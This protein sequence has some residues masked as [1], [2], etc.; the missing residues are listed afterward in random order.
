[1]HHPIIPDI[2]ANSKRVDQRSIGCLLL[3]YAVSNCSVA[4]GEGFDNPVI[5]IVTA[6]RAI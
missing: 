3:D 2:R 4:I 6:M 1:M 5:P